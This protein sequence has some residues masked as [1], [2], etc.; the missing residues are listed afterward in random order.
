MDFVIILKGV[1]EGFALSL[2]MQML[3]FYMARFFSGISKENFG[4]CIRRSRGRFVHDGVRVPLTRV[5]GISN[6]ESPFSC[7]VALPAGWEVS[8]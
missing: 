4:D 1:I 2:G 3:A 8:C 6:A 7:P 5:P